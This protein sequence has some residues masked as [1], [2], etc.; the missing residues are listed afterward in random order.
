MMPTAAVALHSTLA[1]CFS[2]GWESK[3]PVRMY[4]SESREGGRERGF[5]IDK[6]EKLAFIRAGKDDSRKNEREQEGKI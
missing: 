4:L 1:S 3:K 5:V 2:K 6:Y